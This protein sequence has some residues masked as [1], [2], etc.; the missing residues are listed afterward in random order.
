MKVYLNDISTTPCYVYDMELLS[1][2]IAEIQHCIEGNPF[3]VHYAIKANYVPEILATIASHGVGADLVSGYEL[4]AAL[5][6]GFKPSQLVFSGVGK[7]DWEI[8]LGLDNDIFCFNVESMPELQNINDLAAACGKIANVAIRVNPNINAHTHRY[9]TTGVAENK[10]GINL[11]LLDQA[12]DLALRLPCVHLRGLHFH[13]G[14]QVMTMRPYKLLCGRINALQDHFN[15]KGVYFEIINAGGGLG[16]D[17]DNPDAHPIADFASFFDVFKDNLQLRNGQR[18]HFE[19]G[20]S[21]VAQC[22]TLLSRVLY[23]KDNGNKQFII[24]DAGMTDMIRPALYQAHHTIQNLTSTSDGWQSYD[25]VGPVCESSDVF[26]RDEQLPLTQRGDLIA[27]RSCGAYGES[28]SSRYNL[29]P[30]P[31]HFF[32]RDVNMHETVHETALK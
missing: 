2:T 30:L 25:V 27:I 6:A 22:G 23:V 9:V 28:M 11:N 32:I 16:V 3:E 26:G 1:A 5:D 10:F 15:A 14:S 8:Q 7:T 31:Q 17:Y 20:R 19:F 12:V 21:I 13:I 29:R 24:L 18:V 4:H